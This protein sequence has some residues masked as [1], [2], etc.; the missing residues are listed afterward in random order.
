MEI[1]C[2]GDEIFADNVDTE[3]IVNAI[4]K[5]VQLF[6]NT[7]SA[8]GGIAITI[9]DNETLTQLNTQFRGINAPTDVLSFKNNPDPD[10]PDVDPTMTNH[11][12]DIII[13]YPI[14]ESQATTSG[15]LVLEE[16]ILLA[17]HGTL[18]LLGFDHDTVEQKKDM[19]AAQYWAMTELGLAHVQPTEN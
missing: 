17:V 15:H 7:D 9:T 12:G 19:W 13:S 10:F 3:P 2:Q 5:T 8:I 18:H 1:A 14:A 4:K 6:D 11:L 16:L